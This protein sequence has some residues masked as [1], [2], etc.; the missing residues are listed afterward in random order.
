L[1]LTRVTEV[2]RNRSYVIC[3]G[4]P[5]RI[6]KEKQ[7]HYISIQRWSGR[8]NEEDIGRA[9][10]FPELNV[11]FAVGR[12]LEQSLSERNS[13]RSGHRLGKRRIVRTRKDS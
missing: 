7:L 12:S 13:E 1:I 6:C 3:S 11:Q 9:H 5:A 10:V 2:R 4:T 8:L